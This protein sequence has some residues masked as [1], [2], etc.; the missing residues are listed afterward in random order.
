VRLTDFWERMELAFGPVYARS[1][2]QDVVLA[3]LGCTVEQAL[4]AGTDA[5]EVWRAVCQ[6]ADVPD[7]IA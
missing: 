2:A 3:P 6:P 5:K 4:A 1:W 7:A